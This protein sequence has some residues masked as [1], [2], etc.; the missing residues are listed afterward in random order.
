[1]PLKPETI[2]RQYIIDLIDEVK[3][4]AKLTN[5]EP[6]DLIALRHVQRLGV[7]AGVSEREI[8]RLLTYELGIPIEDQ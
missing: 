4:L 7:K 3:A 2:T 1:M 8:E 6:R 5:T